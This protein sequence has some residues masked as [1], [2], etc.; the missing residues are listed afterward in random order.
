MCISSC[1]LQLIHQSLLHQSDITCGMDFI[2]TEGSELGFYD[3][4]VARD[5]EGGEMENAS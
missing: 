3:T 1:T 5:V 2:H 4:W